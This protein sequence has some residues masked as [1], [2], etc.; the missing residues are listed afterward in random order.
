MWT[1]FFPA[2]FVQVIWVLAHYDQSEEVYSIRCKDSDESDASQIHP[3][4]V[5]QWDC[6]DTRDYTLLDGVAATC[7]CSATIVPT[8]SPTPEPAPSS[9]TLEPAPSPSTPLPLAAT[10]SDG[11]SFYVDAIWEYDALG[12]MNGCYE[13][14][15]HT[16]YDLP[17]YFRG[18]EK[19]NGE[20]VVLASE[21]GSKV[22]QIGSMKYSEKVLT[23]QNPRKS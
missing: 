14:S 9:S 15:G 1:N 11:D 8:P 18:G 5:V 12:T 17:E 20:P 3:T 23:T 10:C 19:E 16:N 22:S 7:G 4:A 21:Y 2:F 6:Y 13:D